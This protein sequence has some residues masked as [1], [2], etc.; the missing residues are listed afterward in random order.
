MGIQARTHSE[1][2]I[3]RVKQRA[4]GQTRIM[5]GLSGL[6]HKTAE[7]L[8]EHRRAT[9]DFAVDISLPSALRS[10]IVRQ[11]VKTLSFEMGATEGTPFLVFDSTKAAIES[12]LRHIALKGLPRQ[13]EAIRIKRS[14]QIPSSP[15][16]AN[17]SA[18]SLDGSLLKEEDTT[19]TISPKNEEVFGSF[20]ARLDVSSKIIENTS[21]AHTLTPNAPLSH[22]AARNIV[23]NMPIQNLIS[24]T[25]LRGRLSDIVMQD[26]ASV[27]RFK[28]LTERFITLGK[29]PISLSAKAR[30]L[31]TEIDAQFP[32]TE[33]ASL[34]WLMRLGLF[35]SDYSPTLFYLSFKVLITQAAKYFI[36]A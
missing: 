21:F 26:E 12:L 28:A 30:I 10:I 4:L 36:C 19:I 29:E 34:N 23:E 16:L 8:M 9:I 13:T 25:S 6:A 14:T 27:S 15:H 11:R 31:K 33:R 20:E 3:E 35:V 22:K 1:Y 2:I 18:H 17:I 32:P 24:P 5:W 7:I